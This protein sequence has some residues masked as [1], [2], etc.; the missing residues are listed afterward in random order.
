MDPEEVREII[1]IQAPMS[2]A[3]VFLRRQFFDDDT[4]TTTCVWNNGTWYVYL[5]KDHCYGAASKEYMQS[6]IAA[7]LDQCHQ[8]IWVKVDG[9]KVEKIVPFRT[10]PKAEANVL[11]EVQNLCIESERLE[12]PCWRKERYADLIK[13]ADVIPFQNCL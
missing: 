13:P 6:R 7:F 12:L 8:R 2:V 4:Q 10:N 5:R 1:D 3:R 11:Q 9:E